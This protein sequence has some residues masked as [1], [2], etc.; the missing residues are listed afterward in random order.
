[1]NLRI[2]LE[3]F[4]ILQIADGLFIPIRPRHHLQAEIASAHSPISALRSHF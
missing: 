1:M 4:R 3:T 2:Y